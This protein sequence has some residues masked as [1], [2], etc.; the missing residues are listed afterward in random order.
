MRRAI[1]RACWR[2]GIRPPPAT[3][4]WAARTTRIWIPPGPARR[5]AHHGLQQRPISLPAHAGLFDSGNQS[6]PRRDGRDTGK[7][8]NPPDAG[9]RRE[10]Y[11]KDTHNQPR[12]ISKQI[13]WSYRS[14]NSHGFFS[15]I[16]SSGQRLPNGNTFI[17]SDTEGHFFEVT[18]KGELA[19]EYINP[20]TRDGPV[21]TLG[22]ALPMV[23]SA[24][25]AYRYPADHPAF[26]GRDLTPKGTITERAAQGI[27]VYR[28]R[29]SPAA[30]TTPKATAARA[31]DGDAALPTIE[32]SRFRRVAVC[33]HQRPFP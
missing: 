31:A 32:S 11:D 29:P 9:Y 4:K 12:Q 8:V 19:W 17:C 23:N 2:T 27:D 13:V 20:V 1:R 6:L 28:K 10:T 22:D 26:K 3:S 21:K 14:V 16:G 25:R 7:Y 33:I 24:F 18:D 15:H 30:K 5:G